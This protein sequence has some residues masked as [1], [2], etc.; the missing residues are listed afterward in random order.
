MWDIVRSIIIVMHYHWYTIIIF[1]R[2]LVGVGA[3]TEKLV[4]AA[5]VAEVGYVGWGVYYL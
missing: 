5:V 1:L 3:G 2:G 4:V